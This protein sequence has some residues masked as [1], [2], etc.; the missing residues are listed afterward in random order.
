MLTWWSLLTE[1]DMSVGIQEP[2]T[3]VFDA[4][5]ITPRARGR[6][7]LLDDSRRRF[8]NNG[9]AKTRRTLKRRDRSL[10]G[11]QIA[12]KASEERRNCDD[13]VNSYRGRHDTQCS[14]LTVRLLKGEVDDHRITDPSCMR[15][16]LFKC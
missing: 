3:F 2:E 13:A 1:P 14:T 7:D 8:R 12:G 9:S 4:V 15:D 10:T 5:P 11:T 16:S 6:S